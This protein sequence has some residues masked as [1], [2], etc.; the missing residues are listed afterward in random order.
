MLEIDGGFV[1]FLDSW[2]GECSWFFG[3]IRLAICGRFNDY[4]LTS[5][6][7]LDGFEKGDDNWNFIGSLDQKLLNLMMDG[8]V[9]FQ[10]IIQ[11]SQM[12]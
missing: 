10:S 3:F 6:I 8:S 2:V 12:F 4:R 5:V 1:W 11:L 9:K 7:E